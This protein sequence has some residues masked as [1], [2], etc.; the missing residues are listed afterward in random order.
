MDAEASMPQP[1]ENSRCSR[2]ALKKGTYMPAADLLEK[3]KHKLKEPDDYRVILLNDNYTTMEFV[4]EVLMAVFHKLEEDAVR[5]MMDVHEKGKGT[6]GVY[7][8]DIAQTRASQVHILARRNDFP[9]KCVV[10]KA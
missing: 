8:W 5:I 7:T 2:Y 1:L 9:L 10:E 6:V 4:V 3:K